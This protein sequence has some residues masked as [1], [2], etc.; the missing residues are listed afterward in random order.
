MSTNLNS[1]GTTTTLMTASERFKA[2]RAE[3][4]QRDA[5][6]ERL[7]ALLDTA[8]EIARQRAERRERIATACL[9]ALLS[10]DGW[11]RMSVAYLV[12]HAAGY[13]DELIAELGRGAQS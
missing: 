8:D 13:A 2:L 9:A 7:R 11:E 3:I 5:E 12:Q 10:H 1:D 6:I 4:A